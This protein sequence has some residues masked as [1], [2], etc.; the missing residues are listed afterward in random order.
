LGNATLTISD[1]VGTISFATAAYTVIENA[2]NVVLAV[3]RSGGNTGAISANYSTSDG[4]AQGGLDY[5]ATNAVVSWPDSDL[6]T[7][8]ITVANIND[9][10]NESS[11]TFNVTLSSPT[12]GA[13]LGTSVATVTIIDNDGAAGLDPSFNTGT[14]ANTNINALGVQTNGA[15]VIGG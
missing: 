15:I 7:K 9:Q 13:T 8:F 10:R 5:I 11:E 4:T 6:A 3:N 2:T 14:G 1:N 12:A